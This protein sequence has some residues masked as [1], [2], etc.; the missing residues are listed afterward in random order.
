MAAN[1]SA[2]F[3]LSITEKWIRERLN[4]QKEALGEQESWL[5]TYCQSILCLRSD[6]V[7]SLS[8]PGSYCEK[9]THLGRSLVGFTRLKHLD[10]SR[11]ALESLEASPLCLCFIYTVYI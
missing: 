4:L 2:T 10:L 7:R 8:L 11:N 9:I 5:C 6:D 3:G 1:A